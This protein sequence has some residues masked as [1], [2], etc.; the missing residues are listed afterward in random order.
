P[1]VIGA[2]GL[3]VEPRD[4]ARLAAALRAMWLDD[5]LHR[6]SASA[7]RERTVEGP[8]SWADVAGETRA[9]YSEAALRTG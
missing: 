4:P 3:L 2:A 7:A 6:R 5:D 8:R 1:E 9:V